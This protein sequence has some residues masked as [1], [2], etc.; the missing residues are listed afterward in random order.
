MR[1]S[2]A[3]LID[4]IIKAAV[5][6]DGNHDVYD[7]KLNSPQ[8]DVVPWVIYFYYIAFENNGQPVIKHYFH[9]EKKEIPL[10]EI[11]DKIKSL[12][13]RAIDNDPTLRLIGKSFHEI[14]WKH[15]SYIALFMDSAYWKILKRD[16]DATKSAVVFNTKKGG[17]PNNSF[18]DAKDFTVDIGTDGI[19]ELRSAVYFINHMKK[20]EFGDDIGYDQNGADVPQEEKYSFDIYFDVRREEN[21]PS[22]VFIIDPDGTNMGPPQTPP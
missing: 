19:S 9:N 7:V 4:N 17:A 20:S 5:N 1:K 10:E 14:V 16:S 22:T 11:E 21:G 12:A 2:T 3:R 6:D 15:K 18:F 8:Y 13:L